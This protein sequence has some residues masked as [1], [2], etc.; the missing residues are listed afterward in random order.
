MTTAP[1]TPPDTD[2]AAFVAALRRL[3]AWSGLSYRRLER[4]A[5][6]AGHVLPHS[7]AATMLGR[8]RL[9]REEPLAAFVAA[10]G[11]RGAEAEA[12]TDARRRIA[13]GPDEVP[14]AAAVRPPGVDLPRPPSLARPV[15]LPRPGRRRVLAVA[16]L[17]LT[18]LLGGAL[19]SGALTEDEEVRDTR[20]VHYD[21]S[22]DR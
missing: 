20:T 12:W 14:A 21:A 2:P 4:L 5:T 10:C 7:T 19:T 13:C 11:L 6:E 22:R 9:P 8:E 17:S 16:A 1:P 15:S 3:K 18:A